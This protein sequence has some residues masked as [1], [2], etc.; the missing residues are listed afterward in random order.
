MLYAFSEVFKLCETENL[1]FAVYFTIDKH[2]Y[3]PKKLT[4]NVSYRS[5]LIAGIHCNRGEGGCGCQQKQ[6]KSFDQRAPQIGYEGIK[7]Y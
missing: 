2:S 7:S 6:K 5:F 4:L 1:S 3:E